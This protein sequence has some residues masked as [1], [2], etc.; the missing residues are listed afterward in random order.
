METTD[1]YAIYQDMLKPTK[2]GLWQ[3]LDEQ[4]RRQSAT[5]KPRDSSLDQARQVAGKIARF[6]LAAPS[7]PDLKTYSTRRP[8]NAQ[9]PAVHTS[10]SLSRMDW[11]DPMSAAAS[12]SITNNDA[13]R[14]QR[15]K[16][17]VVQQHAVPT[18][19]A[20]P[21]RLT[22]TTA[23]PGIPPWWTAA[24]VNERPDA[25]VRSNSRGT[26][27]AS[28]ESMWPE[29]DSLGNGRDVRRPVEPQ[30]R[31]GAGTEKKKKKSKPWRNVLYGETMHFHV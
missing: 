30:L 28:E 18:N 6:V 16:D 22:G 17:K 2:P 8:S 4:H 7:D 11:M 10:I 3:K 14:T 5:E 29:G 25:P 9:N 24:N 23:A 20:S 27:T 31:G 21:S 1:G 15:K 19:Q 26:T 13:W 12:T